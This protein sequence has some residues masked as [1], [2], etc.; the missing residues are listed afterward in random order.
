MGIP[1]LFRRGRKNVTPVKLVDFET[2]KN[3][4]P[5]RKL[6]IPAGTFAMNAA[7]FREL[8]RATTWGRFLAAGQSARFSEK[9]LKKLWVERTK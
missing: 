1:R 4:A 5:V 3:R 8:N 9:A 2:C 7:V 6:E